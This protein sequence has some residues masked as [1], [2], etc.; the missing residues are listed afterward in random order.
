MEP[1]I[2]KS[3]VNWR[4]FELVKTFV[5][6]RVGRG[7]FELGRE[8]PFNPTVTGRL[9]DI[10]NYIRDRFPFAEFCIWDSAFLNEFTQHL[11][12]NSFLLIDVERDVAESVYNKLKEEHK[13]V[14]YPRNTIGI[15]DLLPDF[16]DPIL[17]RPLI[18][19]SPI[20]KVNGIPTVTIEK[21]LADIYCD[22]EFKFL[23]GSELL[24][25]YRN[26]FDRYTVNKTK[27]YRYAARKGK[28]SEIQDFITKL[29]FS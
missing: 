9:K 16:N 19:E 29:K 10:G 18:S 17:V 4:V 1:T 28:K 2:K 26:V 24:A 15:E 11:I 27:L 22:P 5:L 3:T 13:F 6:R 23:Q 12:G 21:L 25:I 8:T 20:N 7:M 14:F